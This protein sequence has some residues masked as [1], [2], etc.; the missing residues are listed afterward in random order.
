M[1]KEKIKK[2]YLNGY[3]RILKIDYMISHMH[4]PSVDDFARE[5]EASIPT[6]NRDLRDLR[7]KFGAED[8]L[9]YDRVEKG[10]YYTRPSFRIPAMLTSEKQIIA[11]RLMANLLKLIKNT[12]FT[13]R[14]LKFSLHFLTLSKMIQS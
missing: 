12:P 11:A 1:T 6:I 10:F 5:T 2:Q 4:Y 7:L 8:I 9:K 3:E 13:S 14:R